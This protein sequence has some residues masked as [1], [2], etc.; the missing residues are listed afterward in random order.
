MLY[1][2]RLLDLDY[3]VDKPRKN[4]EMSIKTFNVNKAQQMCFQGKPTNV[5]TKQN[6]SS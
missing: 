4:Q 1:F 3:Y 6:N 2:I 5:W